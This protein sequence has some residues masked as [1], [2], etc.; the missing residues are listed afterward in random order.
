MVL[1]VCI[2]LY[3]VEILVGER[4][5]TKFGFLIFKALYFIINSFDIEVVVTDVLNKPVVLLVIEHQVNL[6]VAKHTQL[7]RLLHETI[8]PLVLDNGP[9]SLFIDPFYR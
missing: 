7:H 4:S 8:S 9:S 1:A 3:M 6:L 2:N 5:Q